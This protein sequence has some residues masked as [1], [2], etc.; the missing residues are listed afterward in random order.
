[1]N[2]PISSLEHFIRAIIEIR[3]TPG[4]VL[5]YRGHR[6][7]DFRLLPSLLRDQKL[8][9]AEPT[10]LRELVASHPAAFDSDTTTLERL[11]RVQHYSLPTRLLD[12]TWNP[13]VALFFAAIG[14]YD[15]DGQVILLRIDKEHLKFFD[16]DT[17]S[18]IAN[19]AHLKELE[20][21]SINFDLRG[22][23]FNDQLHVDRLLQFI[24]TEKPYFR[25]RIDPNHLRTVVCVKPKQ[26]NARILAQAGAFLLF[27]MTEDLDSRPVPGISVERLEIRAR[28]KQQILHE[29]DRMA[30]NEST[31]FPEIEKAA[32]YIKG[33]L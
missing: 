2:E 25:G 20:K 5:L 6:D 17:V 8:L 1:M 14:E 33:K 28:S 24:R 22:K 30:V 29:L 3:P 13:L 16:S 32:L 15:K 10:I 4:E 31:M 26:S 12:G 18:C 11:V 27:G 19:L 21:R 23:E 9:E 7:K